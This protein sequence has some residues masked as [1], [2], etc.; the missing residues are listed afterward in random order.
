[1]GYLNFPEGKGREVGEEPCVDQRESISNPVLWSRA[2]G[3]VSAIDEVNIRQVSSHVTVPTYRVLWA[4]K[5]WREGE[6]ECS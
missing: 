3:F 5:C 1:M 4:R 2:A 6:D